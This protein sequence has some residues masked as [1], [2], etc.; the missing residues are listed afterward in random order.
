MALGS[1][2]ERGR[3][4]PALWALLVLGHLRPWLVASEWGRPVALLLPRLAEVSSDAGWPSAALWCAAA[5]LLARVRLV[6]V[7]SNG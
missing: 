3:L 5:L 4:V 6:A 7:A 2:L 1:V